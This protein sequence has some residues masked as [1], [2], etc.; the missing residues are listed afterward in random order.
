MSF[1]RNFSS[2]VVTIGRFESEVVGSN[3]TQGKK[4]ILWNNL[5][6]KQNKS[7]FLRD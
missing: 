7:K 4:K 5:R 3:P 6:L 2:A 1:T